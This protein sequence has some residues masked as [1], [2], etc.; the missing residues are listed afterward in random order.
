MK[1]KNCKFFKTPIK[2]SGI[3]FISKKNLKKKD[4]LNNFKK[5]HARWDSNPQSLD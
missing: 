5:I 3:D 1:K 4:S 2:F